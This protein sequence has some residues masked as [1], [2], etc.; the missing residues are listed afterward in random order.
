MSVRTTHLLPRPK[1]TTRPASAPKP[2]H[3]SL[4]ADVGPWTFTL[5]PAPSLRLFDSPRRAW[6]P[7]PPGR[8]R[9][10]R[11]TRIRARHPAGLRRGCGHARQVPN[12]TR[13]REIC[14]RGRHHQAGGH[15]SG[16][17]RHRDCASDKHIDHP[18]RQALRRHRQ[19][20]LRRSGPPTSP[21]AR[22]GGDLLWRTV[23]LALLGGPTLPGIAGVDAFLA[24]RLAGGQTRVSS[25]RCREL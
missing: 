22:R 5:A 11:G 16:R 23:L 3:V 20:R 21:S 10:D 25:S 14:R 7:I 8:G 6:Q 12:A 18:A 2:R 13:R 1:K 4:L 17:A 19:Q 15:R 9:T 24:I